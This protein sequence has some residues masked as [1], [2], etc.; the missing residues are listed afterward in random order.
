M[1]TGPIAYFLLLPGKRRRGVDI[2][3]DPENEEP[4]GMTTET[5][6]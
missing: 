3:L 4:A 2:V 6:S 1:A 5:A